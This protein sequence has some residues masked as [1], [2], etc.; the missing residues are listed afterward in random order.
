V[1]PFF[2]F[3]AGVLRKG[4]PGVSA[5][6]DKSGLLELL[7]APVA[8]LGYELIDLD[9]RTGAGGLLRLFIDSQDGVTLDDCEAVSRQ[10]SALLDVEDPMPGSYVLE[11]SSPGIDRRLRTA[12][13]F[14]QVVDE[15]VK[16]Q[17]VR[18]HDG[19]RRFR[20]R[21]ANVDE[22][23]IAVEVDGRQWRLPIADI[24]TATLVARV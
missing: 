4:K 23:A 22:Q 13:H 10:I 9:V 20:G 8:A 15:E 1:G 21:L 14:R 11:V 12:R 19:R 6:T 7:E 2:Y 5:V 3:E 24:A 18:P 16:I 17:L